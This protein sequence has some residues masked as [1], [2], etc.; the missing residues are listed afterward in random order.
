MKG[1]PSPPPSPWL[2]PSPRHDEAK[3]RRFDAFLKEERSLAAVA[4]ASRQTQAEARAELLEFHKVATFFAQRSHHLI[5]SRFTSSDVQLAADMPSAGLSQVRPPPELPPSPTGSPQS[6]PRPHRDLTV[7]SPCSPRDLTHAI[8]RTLA[9]QARAADG[10]NRSLG[11]LG[12]TIDLVWIELGCTGG[13][14]AAEELGWPQL[15][16]RAAVAA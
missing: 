9:A 6:S 12:T 15:S 13:G 2:R 11:T 16:R 4:H 10:A 3:Q 7:I 14:A 1:K 5:S 8:G